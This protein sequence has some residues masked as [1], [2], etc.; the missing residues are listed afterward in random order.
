MDTPSARWQELPLTPE[1]ALELSVACASSPP[2]EDHW[3]V[4]RL[5]VRGE[6][7]YGSAGAPDA[8]FLR[9]AL[10]AQL[11]RHHPDVVLLDLSAARYEWGNSLVGAFQLVPAFDREHAIGLVVL[12]GPESLAG[13]RALLT[14]T[15]A[16]PPHWL[17]GGEDQAWAEAV[18]QAR[19]RSAA[20][21]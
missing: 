13:L 7:R 4:L 10:A 11:A 19:E 6:F 18:R 14:P 3:D 15:R 20:I 2:G 17:A 16:A 1:S 9:G 8:D 5:R 12:G 21:G